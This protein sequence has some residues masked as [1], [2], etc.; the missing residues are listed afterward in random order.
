MADE[1][2]FGVQELASARYL[3]Q[4]EECIE[5]DVELPAGRVRPQRSGLENAVRWLTPLVLVMLVATAGGIYWQNRASISSTAGELKNRRSAVDLLLWASGSKKT[6]SQGVSDTLK[7]AQRDSAFPSDQMKPA[8]KTE[9]DN[10]DFS[11]LSQSWN[12][13]KR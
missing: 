13:G 5:R 6:F 3:V 11:N 7:R 4:S 2:Q 1:R 8:F 9:F 10:V 12:G